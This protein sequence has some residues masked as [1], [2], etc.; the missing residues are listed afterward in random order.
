MLAPLAARA[1]AA[2]AAD[3]ER[4][5]KLDAQLVQLEESLSRAI[6]RGGLERQVKAL[7][8]LAHIAS[9]HVQVSSTFSFTKPYREIER[10]S[11]DTVES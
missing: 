1:V 10:T 11:G 8:Q 4:A 9:I 2:A 7:E 5:D 3:P 6:P